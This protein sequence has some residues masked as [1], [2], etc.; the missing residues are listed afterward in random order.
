ME[1]PALLQSA[2]DAAGYYTQSS[3]VEFRGNGFQRAK[4]NRA[5]PTVCW[6]DFR[7]RELVTSQQQFNVGGGLVLYGKRVKA[8]KHWPGCPFHN[9]TRTTGRVGARIQVAL[10]RGLSL[11]VDATLCCTTGAGG[12]SIG[13]KLNYKVIVESSPA[14]D[15][16]FDLYRLFITTPRTFSIQSIEL[17]ESRILALYR[18]GLVAPYEQNKYGYTHLHV[19]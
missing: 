15:I 10:C 14:F 13:P 7:E 5:N 9:I 17:A 4:A 1:K 2:C 3:T 8:V 16:I 19:S 6:C 11:L 12:F 18:E